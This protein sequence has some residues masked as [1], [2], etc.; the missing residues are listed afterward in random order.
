M[1]AIRILREEQE[2]IDR[3]LAAFGMGTVGAAQNKPVRPSFFTYS[4]RFIREFIEENHFKKEEI[5]LNSLQENGLESDSGPAKVMLDE[6][7]KSREITRIMLEA[8]ES[9]V[10]GEEAARADIIWA[11]SSYST[12]LRQHIQRARSII[13]PL[14]EQLLPADDGYKISEAFNHVVFQENGADE[15][16]KYTGIIKALEDEILEWK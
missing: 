8:A 14:A 2:L 7:Q 16:E 9:W 6:Q 15:P 12:L 11:A 1:R 4:T 5:L 10:S 13:F 3:F